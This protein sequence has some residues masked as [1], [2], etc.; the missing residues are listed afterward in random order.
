MI[1]ANEAV[2]YE[3]VRRDCPALFRVHEA[4]SPPRL[5]ELRELLAPLGIA[6]PETRGADGEEAAELPP[7]ALQRALSEVRGRPEEHFVSSVVLRSL[8][9][10]IY[11]PEC[12]GHY[13]LASRYYTHFT[14][15]IRRYPDLVVHRR[16]RALLRGTAEEEAARTD[17]PARLPEIGEH[18]STTERRA[19]HSERD[20]LQWKKVRFLAD[21]AGERFQGRITGVQP[22]GLF[23]QL[24][25]L[26]VDGLVPIR[27]LG[28]DFYRFEPEAHR[29]VGERHGQVFQLAGA[30]EVELVGADLRH[31]GLDLR[32]AGSPEPPVRTP[33]APRPPRQA[34]PARPDGSPSG[35][36]SPSRP[37]GPGG[38]RGSRGR[39]TG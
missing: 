18:A 1:A 37:G 2:A 3:L 27:T 22:F 8:Q 28:D 12:R 20:L 14:S 31:R 23:V 34:R 9:R 6:L 15:P 24:D 7:A 21:R 36:A 11:S 17:L 30:V 19:E 33:Q 4:P 35:P 5:E 16:L 38:A 10:A 39:R 26:Y 13:A 25:G 32:I 29:L